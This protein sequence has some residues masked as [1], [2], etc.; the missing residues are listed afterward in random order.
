MHPIG[1]VNF[2]LPVS[3]LFCLGLGPLD[4]LEEAAP[5]RGAVVKLLR[6]ALTETFGSF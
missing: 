6:V 2:V 5:L 3:L 1:K 4:H